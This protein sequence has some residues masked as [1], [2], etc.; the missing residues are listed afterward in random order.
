RSVR[1]LDLARMPVY[2][3]QRDFEI[4]RNPEVLVLVGDL[5]LDRQRTVR[6]GLVL[7]DE[8]VCLK[9]A[10]ES[11]LS[12][13]DNRFLRRLGQAVWER[14]AA[15]RDE[16]TISHLCPMGM[17]MH[18]HARAELVNAE[19]PRLGPALAR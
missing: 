18:P 19:P 4:V 13:L 6:S 10:G 3:R 14:G 9:P 17:E 5:E 11:G 8:A 1:T 12:T 15:D 7:T 2:L 16:R